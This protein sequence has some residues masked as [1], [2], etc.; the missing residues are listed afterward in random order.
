MSYP[1]TPAMEA[2][3]SW[4]EEHGFTH[5]EEHGEEY[6]LGGA[7]DCYLVDDNSSEPDTL[8]LSRSPRA[9]EPMGMWVLMYEG[10]PTAMVT[11]LEE[12]FA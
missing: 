4:L 1:D 9:G 8:A 12:E 7:D 3:V 2:L 11:R 10:S 6:W 5:Y